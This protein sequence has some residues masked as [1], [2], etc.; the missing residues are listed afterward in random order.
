MNTSENCPPPVAQR[1]DELQN[2][3]LRLRARLTEIQSTLE[4]LEGT[5]AAIRG[6]LVDAVVVERDESPEVWGFE[7]TD[8]LQMR[9][10]LQAANAG[11][12]EWD[13]TTGEVIWSQALHHLVGLPYDSEPKGRD[14]WNNL[15]HPDDRSAAWELFEK[16]LAEG[17]DDFNH[18]FRIVRP[19][20]VVRWMLSQARIVRDSAGQ[21]RQVFGI[22][23]D[24]TERKLAEETLRQA[25]R[26]KDEFLAMLA[27]ELRNPLAAIQNALSLARV[28]ELDDEQRR[29][30]Q[31]MLDR[32]VG[33]LGRLI[34]DLLDVSRITQ[35]KIELKR[36]LVLV[37]R[38]LQRSIESLRPQI[39]D[40]GHELV[41]QLAEEPLWA[42]ADASRLEQVFVNLLTNA[43][44]YT[45]ERG[46][47]AVRLAREN[48]HA[49]ISF[50]DSGIGISP[51]MLPRV[52]DLFT[53]AEQGLDRA[54][55]G[56]GIGLTLVRRLVEL[57]GGVVSARSEGVG[58]GSE[59]T[60]R[61]PLSDKAG[62]EAGVA[63]SASPTRVPRRVLVVDDNRDAAV[64]LAMLLQTSGHSVSI[65]H[66][67]REALEVA[68][69]FQPQVAL[70]DLG[71]PEMNGF[72]LAPLLR[73]SMPAIRLIALSG[74]GQAEDKLRSKAAGFEDHLVKPT[75]QEE[76]LSLLDAY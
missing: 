36:R 21:P 60:V 38:L 44:K 50:A 26:R 56:L 6:G 67:G 51:E 31:D 33:Q 11:T 62:V 70:L 74:Y 2:E 14:A 34:D 46:Q 57:H 27:H 29:W 18:E 45:H 61:L 75:K 23:L 30:N 10:V 47:I 65:A 55:G 3:N 28:A 71:L 7:T 73:K 76:V 20:G 1:I 24:I 37:Q 69:Q 54:Q 39:D 64:A 49:V 16:T 32:Q 68:G 63:S 43:A 41:V 8:S 22:N 25:D 17:H 12:W 9:L 19:D 42:D 52:F 59:F 5:V 4:E 53:Q 66:S 13:F 72:E 35:L 15:V 58:R 40:L 48:G